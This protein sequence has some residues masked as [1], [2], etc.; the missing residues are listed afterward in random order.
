MIDT[1]PSARGAQKFPRAASCRISLSSVRSDIARRKPQILLLKILHTPRLVGLQAAIF[2]APAVVG[3]L[4]DADPAT[5]IGNRRPPC[6]STISASRSL[7]I[8]SSGRCFLLGIPNLLR[9]PK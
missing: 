7:P 2:L 1:A 3:L 8:I 5:R 6:A 9:H 4:G